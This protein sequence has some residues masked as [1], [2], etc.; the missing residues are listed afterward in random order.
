MFRFG[1]GP[2]HGRAFHRPGR[3]AEP[4]RP[5]RFGMRRPLRFLIDHLG[6]DDAQANELS[7]AI[8]ELRLEREQA[9][10]DLRRAQSKLAD[11]LE[12]DPLDPTA[13]A[14]AAEMRVAAAR[15]ERDAVV[16]AFT[17]VH[18]TLKPEQR[19]KLATLIRTGP[20]SL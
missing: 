7:R 8:D 16:A 11:L 3:P 5:G 18:A 13:L 4:G 12:T 17:R 2:G 14:A 9:A 1:H 20:F 19:P 10:L 6:L 15:R